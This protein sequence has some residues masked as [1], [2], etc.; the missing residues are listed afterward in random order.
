MQTAVAGIRETLL[1]WTIVAMT[2]FRT[3][4]EHTPT[5]LELAHHL[6]DEPSN[7]LWL[8]KGVRFKALSNSPC[9]ERQDKR[10]KRAVE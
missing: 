6:D 1:F 7:R 2:G 9:N 10:I 3:H 5:M 8:I 4:P